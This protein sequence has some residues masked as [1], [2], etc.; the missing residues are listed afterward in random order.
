[1]PVSCGF[2]SGATSFSTVPL[3]SLANAALVGAKTVNGPGPAR[4]STRPAA[5]TAVTSVVKFL[6]LDAFS[7][8]TFDDSMGAP[9]TITEVAAIA[10]GA[11]RPSEI[12]R[13]A[14]N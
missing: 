5:L 14:A 9:P 2:M 3:G 12:T 6:A 8:M 4:V 11:I 1:M 10:A 7:G 13:P